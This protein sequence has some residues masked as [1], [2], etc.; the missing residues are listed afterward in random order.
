MKSLT[1]LWR[2]TALEMGQWCGTSTTRDIGTVLSRCED[3]GTSFLTITLPDFEKA[4]V[5]ALD[6]GQVSPA[7]FPS[8]KHDRKSGR[9][10]VFML[11]FTGKVFDVESG[12]LLQ[13]PCVDSIFAI[14]QLC[15]MFSKIELP[16]SYSRTVRAMQAYVECEQE[17][18][19]WEKTVSP[20]LLQEFREAS[21]LLFAGVFTSVDNDV[22]HCNIVP[23]HGPGSTAD[24]LLGNQKY[25][26]A[27]WT[28]RLESVFPFGEYGLPNWGYY[29]QLDHVN[30]LE[31]GAER[32]VKVIAVPKTLRSPR[33]IAVEP[34]CMQYMQQGLLR[35]LVR[36]LE[37]SRQPF[38]GMIGFK[39]QQPN[40]L[41]ALRGSLTGE[42]ATLDLKEAS[43]RVPNLLVRLMLEDHP[44]LLAGVEACRSTRAEIPELGLC[45]P[46][47]RK[48]ASMGSAVCF[49]FE[50]MVF[51][52]VALMGIA[53]SRRRTLSRGFVKELRGDV[54]V[55][56]DDIIVPAD[57][58]DQVHRYLE[59]FGFRVNDGK[60]FWNGKFRESCG[61]DFYNG[62]DVTPVRLKKEFPSGLGDGKRVAALV[63]FRNRVYFRGMWRTARYL[64]EKLRILLR[65]FFPIVE[66][67]SPALGR[68]SFLPYQEE[69]IDDEEHSPK[70]RAFVLR[71]LIPENSID[72]IAALMKCLAGADVDKASVLQ[73][74]AEQWF[75]DL[76]EVTRSSDSMEG[77]PWFREPRFVAP[78]HLLLSGRATAVATRL[79]W[80]APF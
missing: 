28:Q 76:D 27:E 80:V 69:R 48:F 26:L 7:D 6:R 14:R 15:C 12:L 64:D 29:P 71:P 24:G 13:E 70:V 55:Y 75:D 41:M 62:T 31:P 52:A 21:R 46:N 68:H 16:C 45:L 65:G 22:Y 44:W 8:F 11:G 58:V 53:K 66:V 34:T 3:E 40:R 20:V 4:F 56:G 78:D 61:G 74:G 50:A 49:P 42:L 23:R 18:E 25:S 54:R 43:D 67:S 37:D 5:R 59:L 33:I 72:G 35:A 9:L 51:L 47:L 57:S 63:E 17:V 38:W 77:T 36:Q 79:K 39:D 1:D 73:H 19:E 30:F 2:V 10:P 32:P 60:S